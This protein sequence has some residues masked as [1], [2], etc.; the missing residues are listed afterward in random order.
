MDPKS[1]STLK[2]CNLHHRSIRVQNGGLHF[3]DPPKFLGKNTTLS[4]L[5][6]TR[7]R[8]KETRPRDDRFTGLRASSQHPVLSEPEFGPSAARRAR[9]LRTEATDRYLSAPKLPQNRACHFGCSKGVSKPVQVLLNGI[10]A[11]MVLILIILK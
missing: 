3:L 4:Q 8:L 2:F 6:E 11:V 1:R 10:E 5:K 9:R 7:P